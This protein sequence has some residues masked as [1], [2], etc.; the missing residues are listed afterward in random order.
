MQGF[1][2]EYLSMGWWAL[3]FLISVYALIADVNG[4]EDSTPRVE[5]TE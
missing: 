5:K 2:F 1:A 3:A 4:L